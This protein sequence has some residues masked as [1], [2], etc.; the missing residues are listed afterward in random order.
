MLHHAESSTENSKLETQHSKL[1]FPFRE[2]HTRF[3]CG[4]VAVLQVLEAMGRPV[5][6][7]ELLRRWRFHATLDCTDTP[8]HHLRMARTLDVEIQMA[9]GLRLA[10]LRRAVAIGYPV[11]LLVGLGTC[12]W[13]WVVLAGFE[14]GR[15]VVSWGRPERDGSAPSV[16][17]FA[18]EALERILAPGP[19]CRVLALDRLA[20]V[21]RPAGADLPPPPWRTS[22]PLR[23]WHRW[24]AIGEDL[25]LPPIVRL[26]GFT[27]LT[28]AGQK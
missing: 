22:E 25:F 19:L 6:R 3:D 11:I 10:D 5:S 28:P 13:H 8:G 4:P 7:A 9:R 2:M 14:R 21:L 16:R 24:L 23:L 27:G 20:Y 1:H 12:R 17:R 15:A 18:P 26:A